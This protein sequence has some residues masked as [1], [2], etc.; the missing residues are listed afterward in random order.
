VSKEA[1][2][3]PVKTVEKWRGRK[4]NQDKRYFSIIDRELKK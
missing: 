3:N 4:S 1:G 2:G